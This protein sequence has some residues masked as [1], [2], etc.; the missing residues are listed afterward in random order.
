M[1]ASATVIGVGNPYRRDDGVGPAVIARLRDRRLPG[2]LLAECDGEASRLLELW[3]DAAVVIV[4]DAVRVA[5]P[6]SPGRV[7]RRSLHHPAVAGGR[8]ATAHAADLGGVVE[9]AAVLGRLPQRLLL[10]GVEVGD[11][12]FGPGLTP[13]VAAA[14][15]HLTDEIARMLF[16]SW[17]RAG[18]AARRP[19]PRRRPPGAASHRP[20]PDRRDRP[21]PG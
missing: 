21:G 13:A 15:D 7:H 1:T 11:T 9:L 2:V 14:A 3:C 18:R 6:G 10:Y 12:S 19:A 20:R 17:A 16:F 8:I 4:V 5:A